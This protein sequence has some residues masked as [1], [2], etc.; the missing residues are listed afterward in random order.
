MQASASHSY[1]PACLLRNL[2]PTVR[3]QIIAI[4]LEVL[5]WKTSSSWEFGPQSFENNLRMYELRS[6]ADTLATPL[7]VVNEI[8]KASRYGSRGFFLKRRVSNI[9]KQ[10]VLSDFLSYI[11]DA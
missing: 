10:R 4:T 8:P 9:L 2:C 11:I 1:H 6:V 7:H 5:T 3:S